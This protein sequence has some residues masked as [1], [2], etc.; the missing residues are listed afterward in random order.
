MKTRTEPH[1][2]GVAQPE[3]DTPRGC[4]Q[5]LAQRKYGGDGKGYSLYRGDFHSLDRAQQYAAALAKN[6][7]FYTGYSWVQ[8]CDVFHGEV[9]D[10]EDGEW[11]KVREGDFSA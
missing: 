5:V 6:T 2:E 7:D 4:F 10:F 1:M 9:W 3:N 8:V 11:S